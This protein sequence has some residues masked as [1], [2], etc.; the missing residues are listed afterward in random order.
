MRVCKCVRVFLCEC[1]EWVLYL[2]RNACKRVNHAIC[3]SKY[4]LYM[5]LISLLS[6]PLTCP[7]GFMWAFVFNVTFMSC[8]MVHSV[9]QLTQGTALVFKV[10]LLYAIKQMWMNLYCLW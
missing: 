7:H 6:V 1:A 2:F 4:M 9:A 3:C 10:C 8:Y 5:R